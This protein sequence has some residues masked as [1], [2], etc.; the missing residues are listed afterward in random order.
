MALMRLCVSSR[1]GANT[2]DVD[3]V[4]AIRADAHRVQ[5]TDFDRIDD[6]ARIAHSEKW[7]DFLNVDLSIQQTARGADGLVSAFGYAHN[8]GGSGPIRHLPPRHCRFLR[9]LFSIKR[10]FVIADQT[11]RWR[12]PS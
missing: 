2:Q 4:R 7:P 9:F 8:R 6:V 3:L 1:G 10:H 12:A 11:R 5:L